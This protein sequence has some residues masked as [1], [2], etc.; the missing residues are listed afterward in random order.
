MN[1]AISLQSL[2]YSY[3]SDWLYIN[4]EVLKDL[5]LDIRSGEAFGFLGHN[6][7]G[8]TTT[9]KCI[10]NLCAPKQGRILIEGIPS[11]DPRAR[12]NIGYLP[13]QPYFYDNVTVIETL[14][15]MAD[16]L[17]VSKK[18]QGER[19]DELLAM[20]SMH[21]SRHTRMRNLSKGQMQR[22]GL[23]QALISKPSILILDEPFS[24]LDPIGRKQF[25][26]IFH[27]LKEEGTTLF[28]CSHVLSD[29][30]ALCDRVSILVRGELK[31]IFNVN[32]IPRLQ[33]QKFEILLTRKSS[34]NASLTSLREIYPTIAFSE[35]GNTI[36]CIVHDATE[37]QTLL[38]ALLKNGE[39]ILRFEPLGQDLETL[40][41]SI[42]EGSHV[43]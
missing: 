19:I 7:A 40:F 16:L 29:I 22:V 6:G 35:R 32:D 30:E 42:V 20:L 8:K 34:T 3:R 26:D 39:E 24:G 17:G 10:L 38:A 9:I 28:M 4:K 36:Q 31:G 14:A 33:E 27:N 11:I 43:S 41:V 25:R 12:K 1:A 5:S 18:K 13:E 23:A 2:C 37:A 15:L 21:E